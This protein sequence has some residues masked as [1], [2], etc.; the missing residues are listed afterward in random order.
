MTSRRGSRGGEPHASDERTCPEMPRDY[1]PFHKGPLF[2]RH[3]ARWRLETDAAEMTLDVLAAGV[4]L[5]RFSAHE[6]EDDYAYRRGMSV[7]LDMCCD[8]GRIRVDNLWR[9]PPKRSVDPSL[10]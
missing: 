9:T 6:H 8:G 1:D 7:P 2:S 5:P 10:R 3:K 4:Y